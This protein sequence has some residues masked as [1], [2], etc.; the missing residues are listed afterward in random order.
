M[1]MTQ[2]FMMEG[3]GDLLVVGEEAEG[4]FVVLSCESDPN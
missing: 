3:V 1:D 4:S 2:G